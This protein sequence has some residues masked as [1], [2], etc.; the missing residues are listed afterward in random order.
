MNLMFLLAINTY[1]DLCRRL[2]I[3]QANVKIKY[4]T[5]A[6]MQLARFATHDCDLVS[7]S[8]SINFVCTDATQENTA[9]LRH[10][11]ISAIVDWH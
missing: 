7:R 11:T 9:P 3:E 2:Q 5:S 10:L 6:F 8:S 1:K 4:W